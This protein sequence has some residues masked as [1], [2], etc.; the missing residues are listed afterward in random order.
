[1]AQNVQRLNITGIKK[2]AEAEERIKFGPAVAKANKAARL[3][4]DPMIAEVFEIIEE[5][6]LEAFKNCEPSDTERLTDLARI[7]AAQKR[8]QEGFKAILKDGQKARLKLF[9]RAEEGKAK[10]TLLGRKRV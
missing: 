7:L 2:L 5:T 10:R 6:C 9:E 4:N 1:M 3:I 8:F